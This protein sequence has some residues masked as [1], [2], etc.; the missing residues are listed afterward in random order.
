MSLH[1]LMEDDSLN[2]MF[3]ESSMSLLIETVNLNFNELFN[4]SFQLPS[5]ISSWISS[6]HFFFLLLNLNL[7]ILLS[8]FLWC[9]TSF[10]SLPFFL[11]PFV[12][13]LNLYHHFFYRRWI[14]I[15]LIMSSFLFFPFSLSS[16]LRSFWIFFVARE[17]WNCKT[18]D[19][20]SLDVH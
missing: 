18:K 11:C 9:L 19:F 13:S 5:F 12:F 8:Y 17:F 7:M 2:F 1:C 20:S 4:F 6:L 14:V 3:F 16:F 10:L 15:S